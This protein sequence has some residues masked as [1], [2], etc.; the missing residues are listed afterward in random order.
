MVRQ[1]LRV[2]KF[3]KTTVRKFDVQD[4]G[5]LGFIEYSFVWL[6]LFRHR[7]HLKMDNLTLWCCRYKYLI[8]QL[9]SHI[10]ASGYLCNLSP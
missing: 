7:D 3:I 6:S 4:D 2:K 9:W 5:K 10:A 1:H 8:L